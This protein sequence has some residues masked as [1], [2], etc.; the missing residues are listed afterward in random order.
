[1]LSI[2]ITER[3][4]EAREY[5]LLAIRVDFPY[6]DPDHETTSGR[7]TFELRD[8]DDPANVKLRNQY[9]NPSGYSAA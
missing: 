3:T 2:I 5:S 8:Y 7:G 6:E 9:Y 4:V 1:M